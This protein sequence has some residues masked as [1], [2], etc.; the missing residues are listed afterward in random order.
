MFTIIL[1]QG[2]KRKEVYAKGNEHYLCKKDEQEYPLL[3]ELFVDDMDTFASIDMED[4]IKELVKVSKALRGFELN[5]VN[6]IILLANECAR[7]K[8]S[9][10]TF[11]PFIR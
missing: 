5:H 9:T 8:K 7:N 4:L 10:L 2:K 3:S 11:N 6:D 1:E